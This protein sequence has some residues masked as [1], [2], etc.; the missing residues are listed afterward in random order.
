[1]NNA[2]FS[3]PILFLLSLLWL[4]RQPDLTSFTTI[5]IDDAI[6]L[7]QATVD[8]VGVLTPHNG[9]LNILPR[10]IASLAATF[11]LTYA[12]VVIA[13]STALVTFTAMAAVWWC[14]K[15]SQQAWAPFA[16]LIAG[17]LAILPIAST[18]TISN[19]ACLQWQLIAASIVAIALGQITRATTWILGALVFVTGIAT[20]L[21]IV[22]IPGLLWVTWHSRESLPVK[23]IPLVGLGIGLFAQALVAITTEVSMVPLDTPDLELTSST[24]AKTF[25]EMIGPLPLLGGAI[26]RPIVSAGTGVLLLS[27]LG[28]AL[29]V[30][31]SLVFI[32]ATKAWT[33]ANVATHAALLLLP[34][35]AVVAISLIIRP[36]VRSL[37][38]GNPGG[39]RYAVPLGYGIWVIVILAIIALAMSA[40]THRIA[41]AAL[42]PML[43][44]SLFIFAANWQDSLGRPD[45]P[46]WSEALDQ[47]CIGQQPGQV[48]PIFTSPP[49]W[50][51]AVPCP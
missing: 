21:A 45:G 7:N 4:F 5:Y 18:E 9:Y 12:P 8:S 17:S 19:A 49:P 11:P 37:S 41:I 15:G 31:L 13:L 14:I 1:M 33:G 42:V 39:T 30:A 51:T 10:L 38:L 26:T 43:A 36:A 47:A 29:A 3:L 48:V 2:A 32:K 25:L 44:I 35:V 27:F 20:P 6:F 50:Q 34:G 24:T 28:S 46:R 16:W 40:R 23:V 22:L